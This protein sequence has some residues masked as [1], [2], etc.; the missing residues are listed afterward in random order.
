MTVMVLSV[1]A[2]HLKAKLLFGVKIRPVQFHFSK[3]FVNMFI[4]SW[5]GYKTITGYQNM[6]VHLRPLYQ[7]QAHHV[8]KNP[9]VGT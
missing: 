4:T 9:S 8:D 7:K 5:Q 3:K 6:L 2:Y 1:R